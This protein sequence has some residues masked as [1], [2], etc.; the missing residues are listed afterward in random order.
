[1]VDHRGV[2]IP[3]TIAVDLVLLRS[4]VGDA[5]LR[6][7]MI[8]GGRVT[9][10][11]GAH[12]LLLLQGAPVVAQLPDGVEAGARLRLRVTEA[13]AE[14][15]LLQVV[16]DADVPAAGPAPAVPVP[17][18]AA[19]LAVPLPGGLTAQVRVEEDA[20]GTGGGT[21]GGGGS[22]AVW[23]RLDSP[24]LGRMDVRVDG[25]SCAVAVSAG[26]PADAARDALPALREALARAAGRPLL[27]TL[28]PRTRALDVS[29]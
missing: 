16:P 21:R 6:P 19:P 7:G 27:V 9:E 20:T 18:P 28:H 26:A 29:A 2:S 13:G 1:M 3:P 5:V 12:G 8:L 14:R 15:V 11:V 24:Q 17:V 25:L 10:R 22:G 4:A 23:L